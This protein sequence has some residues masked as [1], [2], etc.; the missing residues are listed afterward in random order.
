L[1]D[2]GKVASDQAGSKLQRVS[3]QVS[4]LARWCRAW[5]KRDRLPFPRSGKR[6]PR[7]RSCP[8]SKTSFRCPQ[9]IRPQT[10]LLVLAAMARW[11]L[12]WG[13]AVIAGRGTEACSAREIASRAQQDL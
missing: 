6:H 10:A 8:E 9:R 13:P 1:V 11:H 2:V 7:R 4:V 3:M 12:S 5:T